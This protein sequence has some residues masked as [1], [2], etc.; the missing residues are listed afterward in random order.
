MCVL[1]QTPL[2]FS[3]RVSSARR[4]RDAGDDDDD[5]DD[6]DSNNNNNNNNITITIVTTGQQRQ[7][8]ERPNFQEGSAKLSYQ[9]WG[10]DRDATRAV[11]WQ[12]MGFAWGRAGQI[13]EAR[14]AGRQSREGQDESTVG[15]WT[16]LKPRAGG[17][18]GLGLG[19]IT[20]RADTACMYV[21]VHVHAPG[22]ST[23]RR[24]FALSKK[25]RRGGD[26]QRGPG[27]LRALPYRRGQEAEPNILVLML[28][29]VGEKV[30]QRRIRTKG[31]GRPLV[32]T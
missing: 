23:A 22:R 18:S 26:Q 27:C 16:R 25:Q 20:A 13:D 5:D 10:G 32:E 14:R 30:E 29:R 28:R 11:L 6:D 3:Q 17:G 12:A 2:S 7:P 1:E 15:R 4:G 19:G 8:V 31:A 9:A 21:H 24:S